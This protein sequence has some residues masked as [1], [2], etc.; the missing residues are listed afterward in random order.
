ML[1]AVLKSI[2]LIV[3]AS[4]LTVSLAYS[5]VMTDGD[6]I[7]MKNASGTL[8]ADNLV[9]IGNTSNATTLYLY[10][11]VTI[12]DSVAAG[13]LIN[14]VTW[15]PT[16][17]TAPAPA[18]DYKNGDQWTALQTTTS[19]GVVSI[20]Y[21]ALKN[22]ATAQSATTVE[23]R[24]SFSTVP[25][26]RFQLELGQGTVATTSL[27]RIYF[28]CHPSTIP[29]RAIYDVT[30]DG[31]VN[32]ADITAVSQA[33]IDKSLT[34]DVSGDG[35]INYV[36]FDMVTFAVAQTASIAG[37]N[38]SSNSAPT[39]V[40]TIADMEAH[41]LDPPPTVDVSGNFSD[42]DGDTLTYTAASS[43][44]SKVTVSV[45]AATVTVTPVAVGHSTITVTATD[46]G[47]LFANQAF[48]VTVVQT[49]RPPT[50]VGTIP[51]QTPPVNGTYTVDVSSYFSDPDGDTL[52]Y[53]AASSDKSKAT[54]SVSDS[55]VT[56]T[57]VAVGT[58]TLT[59]TADDG[60][61]GTVTQTISVSVQ[62]RI[63]TTVGFIPNQT[64]IDGSSALTIDVSPYFSDP[65]G[66]ALTYTASADNTSVA[67]VSVSG[68]TVTIAGPAGGIAPAVRK[69]T[70]VAIT[71]TNT[72]NLSVTSSFTF[73]VELSQADAVP[74]LG[75][76]E[77]LQLGSLLT[78]DTL[79][80]N[81]LRNAS[82]D[83]DDWLEIRNV[84]GADLALDQWQ[85]T[86]RTGDG[87][88]VIPFPDGAV[89][90]AGEV[91]LL[92][93][94]APAAADM[95]EGFP[96]PITSVVS[97]SFALPQEDYAL[98]LRS[99][100]TFGDL[101][102]NYFEGE[103]E[104]PETAPA[105]NVDTVWYRTQPIAS[106]YRAESWMPSTYQDGLG[107]PGYLHP[108]TAMDM[109]GD[110]VVNILDLV[111]VASQL[112][113]DGA[114]AADL[115]GDGVVSVAD[116]VL[117]ADALGNVGGAPGAGQSTAAMVADWLNLAREHGIGQ[118]SIPDGIFYERGIAALEE[119]A[120][121]AVPE[122]T[123]LL[124]NYPNPFNPET[125]IPYQLAKA[126]EVTLSIHSSKGNLV[127]TMELGHQEAG[128]YH[129]RND[130]AY[131]DGLNDAGETVASGVYFYT[132]TAGNFSATRKMLILK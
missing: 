79:I 61:G 76:E 89:I 80:F 92:A 7:H 93:N 70:Q 47:G 24:A 35:R 127:R 48:T 87:D 129:S 116:L 9:E 1:N 94:T 73:A 96:T 78:Y 25:T 17:Q 58:A 107:T 22:I 49:N 23:V 97:E 62:P 81:E 41:L 53:S 84:G 83:A 45:S 110:G 51:E 123:A 31:S 77:L 99:P 27:D 120:R 102:G 55:T 72:Y 104:R 126:A 15:V 33:I 90:P 12:S 21:S 88:V 101:A 36:D 14:T 42:A 29:S 119:L 32:S 132:L 56:I 71:A 86:I 130:A 131:W 16:N 124:A 59:V 67:T 3:A 75:S 44:T 38:Q 91:L 6:I 18:F 5:Q 118:S 39:A 103:V 10:F 8:T 43:D 100:T 2:A 115:N 125:W 63:P 109:N 40:G 74:G 37:D 106:G 122:I 95:W 98:I 112:G 82:D 13:T 114:S 57:G 50:A 69:S 121:L 26:T 64:L 105:L 85:L 46:P 66:S 54:V 60:N 52:T 30:N 108:S 4:F 68:S 34:G 113:Q 111:L 19:S 117:V 28:D 128:T 65:N 11:R 20:A